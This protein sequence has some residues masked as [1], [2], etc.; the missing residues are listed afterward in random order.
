MGL[1]VFG[2]CLHTNRPVERMAANQTD[3]PRMNHGLL[4][5]QK[6]VVQVDWTLG[7]SPLDS[8]LDALHRWLEKES[9][10]APEAIVIRRGMEVAHPRGNDPRSLADAVLDRALPPDD[11]YFIYVLFSDRFDRYRGITWTTQ[12]LDERV[13]FPVVVMLVESIKH[14]SIFPL[15]RRKIEPA[16]LVHEFGHVAGLVTSGR[17]VHDGHCPNP[18]CRMY[19]GPDARAIFANLFPVLCQWRLPIEFCDECERELATGH[20]PD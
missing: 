3:A 7:E 16:V 2:G 8:S 4:S 6:I 20:A 17:R 15:S 12:D 14:D 18:K 1:L 10:L 5:A 13:L 11:A 9:R 19:H